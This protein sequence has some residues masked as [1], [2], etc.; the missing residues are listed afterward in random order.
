M[1][2]RPLYIIFTDKAVIKKSYESEECS[3]ITLNVSIYYD[4]DALCSRVGKLR[5]VPS[6]NFLVAKYLFSLA[7]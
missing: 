3:K 5:L 7:T 4:R 1:Y 6:R 2:C